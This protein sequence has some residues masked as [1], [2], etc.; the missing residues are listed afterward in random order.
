[1]T[2]MRSLTVAIVLGAMLVAG[3]AVAGAPSE[4]GE[5]AAADQHGGATTGDHGFRNAFAVFLGVTDEPGHG[6]EA[7]W[8]LEY[9]RRMGP[10][11]GLG[12]LIDYAGGEQRNLVV[13]PAVLW[14]PFGGGFTLI[15]APGIEW[16]DGRGEVEH[17]LGKADATAVDEDETY[18]VFRVG[19]AYWIHIGS[20]YGIAPAVNL[21]L[22]DGH[23]VWVYGVNLEVRF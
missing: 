23:E 9:G 13:A 1:M 18:F 12:G 6:S 3:P 17:H 20:R 11:W 19:A 10:R 2:S 15:A 8:G 22:V 5:P 7:T 16:H 21:D 14:Q 4:H